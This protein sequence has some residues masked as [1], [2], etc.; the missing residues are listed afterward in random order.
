MNKHTPA[1]IFSNTLLLACMRIALALSGPHLPD[2]TNCLQ[3]KLLC[4]EI[5]NSA[6]L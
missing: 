1:H 6:V 3:N 2:D 5:C 4:F